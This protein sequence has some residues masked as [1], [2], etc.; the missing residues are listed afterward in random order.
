VG[1]HWED[2]SVTEDKVKELL[3]SAIADGRHTMFNL[4]QMVSNAIFTQTG[5]KEISV[6]DVLKGTAKAGGF[7]KKGPEPAVPSSR[8]REK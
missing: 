1:V 5:M 6:E 3:N 2:P 8:K 4:M 7:G